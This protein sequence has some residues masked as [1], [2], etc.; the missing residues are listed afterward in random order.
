MESVLPLIFVNKIQSWQPV[1]EENPT[2]KRVVNPDS[3]HEPIKKLSGYVADRH[4]TEIICLG[5]MVLLF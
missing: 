2:Y 3:T 5:I 1:N 4:L